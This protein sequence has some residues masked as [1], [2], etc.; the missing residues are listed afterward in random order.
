R[1]LEPVSYLPLQI[2]QRSHR[3]D[4]RPAARRFAKQVIENFERE[5]AGIAR[6]QDLLEEVLE[7]ELALPRKTAVVPG[8]LQHV[9]RQQRRVGEL[10]EENLVAGYLRNA[11]RV[12]AQR[13]RMEAVEDQ[14]QMRMIGALD[15]RPRLRI[16]LHR[17]APGKGL[18]ADAE[19]ALCRPLGERVE[20]SR[21]ALL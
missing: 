13:K 7:V 21:H 18:E 1:S 5:R 4:G 14:A 12:V 9:H 3:I 8:P 15:D 10:Q 6:H 17:P 20:L 19:I 11:G 16:E 2:K